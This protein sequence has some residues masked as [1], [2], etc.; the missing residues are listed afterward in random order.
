MNQRSSVH[1]ADKLELV[2][3]VGR[4][5]AVSRSVCLDGQLEVAAA[6]TVIEGHSH[7]WGKVQWARGLVRND[8]HPSNC[9]T[10]LEVI[11][12]SLPQRQLLTI[13]AAIW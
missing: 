11:H 9:N 3:V 12:T 10:I 2:Y 5:A 7:L 4:S 1:V 6:T 13:W 8:A